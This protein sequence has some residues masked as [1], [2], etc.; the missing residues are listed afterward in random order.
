MPSSDDMIFNFYMK[1]ETQ[2]FSSNIFL[3]SIHLKVLNIHKTIYVENVFY[4]FA[5]PSF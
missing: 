4:K 2:S 1:E 5:L 3:S